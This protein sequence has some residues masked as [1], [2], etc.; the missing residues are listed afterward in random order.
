MS[1]KEEEN[2]SS[3]GPD[4]E[5]VRPPPPPVPY[6]VWSARDRRLLVFLLGYLALASSLTANIYFPL[7][8]LLAGRYGVSAQAINLTITLF[9]IFQGIAPSFW[10]PVSDAFGRRPVYL[11]TFTVYTLASLGLSIVDKSYPALLI[12]RAMQSAGGSAV[13]SLAYAVVADVTV[14][15]ER[16][17]FYRSDDDGS[18]YWAVHW[19][20]PRWCFRVLL[21]FGASGLLLIGLAMPETVRSIVGNGAVP[22][23][24]LWRTWWSL[25]A[26]ND[27]MRYVCGGS[28]F[29]TAKGYPLATATATTSGVE[30]DDINAGK[31]G[32]G[33]LVLPNPFASLRIVFYADTFLTLW[34]A[35]S[36]YALWFC[37]Q[38]SITPIFALGYGFNPLYVGLCFLTGGA[39]IIAGGFITGKLMDANYKHVAKKAGISIDR[40]RGEDMSEF[41]IEHARSRGSIRIITVSLCAVI[42]YGLLVFQAYLGCKCTVLHQVYSALIVDLFPGTPGTAAASNNITRCT[43][44]ALAVAVMNPLVNSMGYGWVF[45]L[46]GLLDALTCISAVLALRRWGRPWREKR[47]NRCQGLGGLS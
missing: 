41:P 1:E 19:S 20:Y 28:G 12:L 21:I 24:S 29:N 14:H 15:S 10:S 31:T 38:T 30:T 35:A 33:R 46:L 9:F 26:R 44:A 39:G 4:A 16:R 22:A 3:A 2:S 7:V 43:T 45:T 32:K 36:P 27:V 6:T 40:G 47:I 8:D 18:K 11:A 13:L 34:L 23:Q 25:L 17:S 37:V 42:G 5:Q